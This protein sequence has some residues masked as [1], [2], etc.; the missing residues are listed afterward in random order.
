[1]WAVIVAAGSGQRFGGPKQFEILNGE[2]VLDRSV[3]LAAQACDG[4]VVVLSPEVM[5]SA[6]AEVPGADL[7][8]AG[9]DTRSESVRRGLAAVPAAAAFVLVHDAARPLTP[10]AVFD[11]VIAALRDGASAVVPVIP[12]ADTIQT[13]SGEV[14]D[15]EQLRAVQTPQG[16]R[17]EALV[18][19]HATDSE[20]TDDAGLME[21]IGTSVATVAGDPSNLKLTNPTDLI[22][23]GA[24][25]SAR[26]DGG[27]ESAT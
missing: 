1:V 27:G 12:L 9:G 10:L 3:A 5:G 14:L 8:V 22:V 6:R 2:R 26:R 19:A 17:R 7:V 21:M 23:A 4:V 16:F 24:L 18:E 13:V 25:L 20:A 15:R 11:R